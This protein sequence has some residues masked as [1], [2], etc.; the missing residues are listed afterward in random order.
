L[1]GIGT[2][3][4]DELAGGLDFARLA[5]RHP[6]AVRIWFERY[7]DIV[8]GFVRRRVARD[9]DLTDDVTQETFLVALR[10]IGEYDPERGAMLPWL[11]Y[12]ARNCA[13]KALRHRARFAD[14][15]DE[16]TGAGEGHAAIDEAPLSEELLTRAETADRVH[17]AFARIAPQHQRL[18]ESHYILR[19]PLKQIALEEDTT[20]SAVKSQLHRARLA[21]KSAFEPANAPSRQ[22]VGGGSR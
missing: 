4:R 3:G 8:H 9:P 20:V 15:V 13:R 18:L 21:F 5:E 10:R 14:T 17:D 11:T 6:D 22:T 1:E 19:Q 16:G 7:F 12:I 2:S